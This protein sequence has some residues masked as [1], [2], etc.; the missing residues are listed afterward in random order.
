MLDVTSMLEEIKE[1]PYEEMVITTPRSG[2]VTFASGLKPGCQLFGPTGNFLE[3]PGT[4]VATVTREHNP[5][6]IYSTEK[7]QLVSFASDLDGKFV[8]AGTEIVRMRHFLSGSEVVQII[9]KKALHLFCAPERAKYYFVP[10]VDIKTKVSGPRAVTVRDGDE[11]F[12][13]SRMKR[14]TSLHYSGPEGIIYAIYFSHNDNIDAGQPLIGVCP[15]DLVD[16]VEDV[17]RRIQTDW[18]EQG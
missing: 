13:V 12:I 17:V 14:E 7:G 8:E 4:P 5:F 15:P 10:A 2:I 6:S 11:L 18:K 16:Q 9:L 1:S 3:K